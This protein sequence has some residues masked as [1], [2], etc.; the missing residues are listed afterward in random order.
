[1]EVEGSLQLPFYYSDAFE[2][3]TWT[4]ELNFKRQTNGVENSTK[5]TSI[6]QA[7]GRLCARRAKL[8]FIQYQTTLMEFKTKT[9][10]PGD[11]HTGNGTLIANHS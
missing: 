2:D 7:V 6:V 3:E 1:M 4:S 11:T 8:F 9:F 10:T 5:C